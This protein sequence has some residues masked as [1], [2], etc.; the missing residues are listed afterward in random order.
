MFRGDAVAGRVRP[1]PDAMTEDVLRQVLHVFW[2]HFR[3]LVH[4]QRPHFH[5]TPPANR[6]ARG[7]AKIDMLFDHVGWRSMLPIGVLVVRPRRTDKAL[8]ILA[9]LV[10]QEH[11]AGYRTT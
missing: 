3:T 8:N 1:E 2:I 5:E 9:E 7:R 6:R 4:E 11:L 10:V